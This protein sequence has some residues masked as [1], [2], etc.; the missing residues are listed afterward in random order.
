VREQA[1]ILF[2]FDQEG[3]LDN[4]GKEAK[5]IWF[6]LKVLSQGWYDFRV[7][8]DDKP[9]FEP[10]LPAHAIERCAATVIFD[11]PA[12]ANIIRS[13]IERAGATVPDWSR[14]QPSQ[15]AASGVAITVDTQT[16]KVSLGQP[17][18]FFG[19]ALPSNGSS[20]VVMPNLVAWQTAKYVRWRPFSGEFNSFALPIVQALL[21]HTQI[22][23]VKLEYWDR[24]VWTG[25]QAEMDPAVLLRPGLQLVAPSVVE[26]GKIWHSHCG[27]F[28]PRGS[29]RRLTNVNLNVVDTVVRPNEGPQPTIGIFTMLQDDYT[30]GAPS[31]LSQPEQVAAKLHD[32]HMDLKVLLNSIISDDMAGRISLQ[33]GEE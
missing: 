16:G 13:A 2:E 22:N 11:R 12:Q 23:A 3:K 28:E 10:I 8:S 5:V 32:L 27:W 7:M 26:K 18:G 29:C 15:P 21:E 17:D 6:R 30:V 9:R 25:S 20:L 33:T 31:P 19:F 1:W 24:F 14:L 4:S